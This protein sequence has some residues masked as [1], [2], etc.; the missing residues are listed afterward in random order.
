MLPTRGASSGA[1]ACC[2]D[3]NFVGPDGY[4]YRLMAVLDAEY[5]TDANGWFSGEVAI[6]LLDNMD[7]YAYD[8]Q[9]PRVRTF[10]GDYLS[11]ASLGSESLQYTHTAHLGGSWYAMGYAGLLR[12]M[13]ARVG[14]ELLFR[15][16]DS[17]IALGADLNWV[18]PR[19]F[20]QGFALRDY[21]TWTGHLSAYV[22][23]SIEDVLAKMSVG[24]YLAG[25]YG[26]T[27]D[28]SREFDSGVRIG[29]WGT[30]TAGDDFSAVRPDARTSAR[31]LLGTVSS[32]LRV[33]LVEPLTLRRSPA[34]C[35][36][37]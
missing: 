2:L 19:D 12:M 37:P 6:T 33:R 5:H 10:I 25:D 28:L 23:T 26:G 4:L 11:E 9:L 35:Q 17:S 24:R 7:N 13:F 34:P 20:D 21:Q 3:Q 30:W 15:P 14:S 27:L 22:E 8:S 31:R 1:W 29:A 16:F 32:D 18:R 36:A